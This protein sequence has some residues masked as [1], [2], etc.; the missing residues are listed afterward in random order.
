MPSK[1]VIEFSIKV[2]D[3]ASNRVRN[4]GDRLVAMTKRVGLAAAQ[5]TTAFA[6][7]GAALFGMVNKITKSYDELDKLSTRLGV[8]VEALSQ[9]QFIA[10]RSGITFRNVTLALQRMGRRI[11][12]ASVG[13]GEAQVALEELNLS[14][15]DLNKLP[16]E[17]QFKAI[18]QALDKTTNQ[19]DRLR[20]AFKLFDSEG[21]AVL[22]M[23]DQG[24]EGFDEMAAKA[25]ELGAVI[26]ED[27][28]N[29]A[30]QFQDAMANLRGAFR[31][32]GED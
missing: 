5:L 9:L 4:I 21:V 14:A 17:E 18:L 11:S 25:R 8:S 3:Q 31:G 12:E 10:E 20:L 26:G 32:L 27:T 24:I 19:A 16:I 2:I 29:A 7:A 1:N 23:L 15:E 6:A 30:A 13:L 28:V 22:Q